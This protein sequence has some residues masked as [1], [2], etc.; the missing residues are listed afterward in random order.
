[1][2]NTFTHK[3]DALDKFL[4]E[5]DE[6]MQA[7]GFPKGL[8]VNMRKDPAMMDIL[9]RMIGAELKAVKEVSKS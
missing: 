9:M 8:M 5:L 1:M 6:K 3:P 2:K 4:Q 7:E